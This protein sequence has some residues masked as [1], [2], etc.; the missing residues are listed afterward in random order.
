MPTIYQ[1]KPTFQSLLRPLVNQLAQRKIT[2]NQITITA[3]ILS[4]SA[5][6]F[7]S[8]YA[9]FHEVLLLMP[10]VLLLRMAFNAIDGMLA[11]EHHLKT[12]LG[13]I[14][15]E[16]GDVISDTALYL[17]FALI[18][19]VSVPLIV[20]IVILSI[21]SE[22]TGV[23]GVT[24]GGQRRYDGPMGKSDRAFVFSIVS[25]GIAFGLTPALWLDLI[26]IAMIALLV[27][28]IFNRIYHSLQD[29]KSNGLDS[30]G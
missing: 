8:L 15:N 13:A 17:P 11:R 30:T 20:A 21:L 23:L 12:P 4:L 5:G 29:V 19:G 24:T 25:L 7:L 10:G 18:A 3:L 28:T 26:W 1:L 6:S 14:L 16:L 22:M 2:P 27:A 9:Q